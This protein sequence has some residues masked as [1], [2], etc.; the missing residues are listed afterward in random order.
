[1]NVFQAFRMHYIGLFL[2]I[3]FILIP[4]PVYGICIKT[5]LVALSENSLEQIDKLIMKEL[6][7]QGIH[8]NICDHHCHRYHPYQRQTRSRTRSRDTILDIDD[9][10]PKKTRVPG[11]W[12]ETIEGFNLLQVA[13]KYS[14]PAITQ[15]L[16]DFGANP[17]VGLDSMIYMEDRL[18]CRLPLYL[19]FE[20]ENFRV[21]RV[22]MQNGASHDFRVNDNGN[23]M[24]H[25]AV[26]NNNIRQVNFL[27]TMCSDLSDCKN[28][29]DFIALQMAAHE[30][31]FSLIFLF[32]RYGCDL[33]SLI[34]IGSASWRV[35]PLEYLEKNGNTL[36]VEILK[37]AIVSS[38]VKSGHLRLHNTVFSLQ[39][40]VALSIIRNCNFS[41]A[42]FLPPKIA[43]FLF[44]E[45][46]N[47]D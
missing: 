31:R 33:S 41:V 45:L 12:G 6:E 21:A 17:N 26:G 3:V 29:D 2:V 5:F 15:R 44:D 20:S 35:T 25:V 38:D 1:M 19:A 34:R 13:A 28:Y 32:I 7:K 24:L 39:A 23:S 37:A 43:K 8:I 4:N 9:I 11:P 36:A 16:I 27:L 14:T 22:L 10:I 30:I 46:C 47:S 40:L 18:D 42:K